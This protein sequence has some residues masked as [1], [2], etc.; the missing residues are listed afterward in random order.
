[1]V[2]ASIGTDGRDGPTDAAGGI[3]DGETDGRM[4]DRGIVPEEYLAQNDSYHALE[5]AGDLLITGPTGT[6]VADL[7]LVAVGKG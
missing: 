1:V 4:R 2:I 3:V 7:C 5:K 6:N